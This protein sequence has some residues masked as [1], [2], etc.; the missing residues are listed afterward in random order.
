MAE[1]CEPQTPPRLAGYESWLYQMP[2]MHSAGDVFASI[3][4]PGQTDFS[5]ESS[6]RWLIAI[7]EVI[8]RAEPASRLKAKIEAEITRLAGIMTDPASILTSLNRDLVDP[9]VSE[10]FATMLVGVIDS[11]RHELTVASAGHPAPFLRHADRQTVLLGEQNAG[12][13]LWIDPQFGYEN[14]TAPI[15]PGEILIF[16]SDGVTAVIDDQCQL[17]DLHRLRQAIIQA[18]DGAASVG[19]SIL[20]AIRRLGQGRPQQDDITLLCLGRVV[21][22]RRPVA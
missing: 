2:F 15:G 16:H 12:Y 22:T 21:P 9:A 19:Q 11:D 10:R 14:V 17:F 13:P 7:G 4:L 6:T 8:G 20:E 3:G 5:G 18:S 1:H